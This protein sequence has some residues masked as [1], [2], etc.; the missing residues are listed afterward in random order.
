MN[1]LAQIDIWQMLNED[2]QLDCSLYVPITNKGL[3]RVQVQWRR[4]QVVNQQ[5]QEHARLIITVPQEAQQQQQR[6][7]EDAQLETDNIKPIFDIMPQLDV[8]WLAQSSLPSADGYRCSF[9]DL[10]IFTNNGDRLVLYG[11]QDPNELV[12]LAHWLVVAAFGPT[13]LTKVHAPALHR[14]K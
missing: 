8:A 7:A 9:S 14:G 10:V 4:P 1:N 12:R 6:P 11:A 2:G 13:E 5:Q 3:R